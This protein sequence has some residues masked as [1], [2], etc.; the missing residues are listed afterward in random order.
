MP[1]FC[2]SKLDNIPMN[3]S[4]C[5]VVDSRLMSYTIN[6]VALRHQGIG[7]QVLLVHLAQHFFVCCVSVYGACGTPSPRTEYLP[8]LR[9]HSQKH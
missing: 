7:P 6:M 3:D 2:F 4:R 1:S 5:M 8:L 9:R